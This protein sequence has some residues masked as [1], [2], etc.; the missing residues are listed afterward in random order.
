MSKIPLAQQY[1]RHDLYEHA[2]QC[3]EAEIDFIDQQFQ[4]LK[5]YPAVQLR[6]DFCGTAVVCCEWVQRR[7]TNQAI[8]IDLDLAVLE[9]GKKHRIANLN[10]QQQAR[11]TL[12]N[13]DVLTTD[14]ANND[15]ILA[16]N[17]S[18]WLF[19]TRDLLKSYF[20]NAYQSLAD[21]GVFFLDAYGGY[22]SYREI[23]ETQLI[24]VEEPYTY[25]WEQA[26]FNPISQELICHIHFEFADHSRIDKAF[27]YDWRL[28][29][30]AEIKELL[31]EVGFKNVTFYWQDDEQVEFKAV[32]SAPADSGWICYISAEKNSEKG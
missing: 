4:Q 31:V 26:R 25:I 3:A 24:D 29:N 17:F 11:I 16:M 23:T 22:D 19:K 12:K 30:L 10:A 32:T 15:I 1:H 28:W 6:E 20:K 13:K 2:V 7:E 5:G 18:Y 21:H 8:G 9:W 27:S 14:E